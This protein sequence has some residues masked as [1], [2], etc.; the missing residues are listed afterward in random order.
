MAI[1]TIIQ[2]ILAKLAADEIAAWLPILSQKILNFAVSR[3]PEEKRKRYVEEWDAHL[4]DIPG[5]F[6]KLVYSA[7]LLRAALK[8]DWIYR[9]G[10]APST[11]YKIRRYIM[12]RQ[13]DVASSI[14]MTI[15][16]IVWL[17]LA[18]LAGCKTGDRF[19]FERHA[20][21]PRLYQIVK[22]GPERSGC[23]LWLSCLVTVSVS[24]NTLSWKWL[25]SMNRKLLES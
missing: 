14:N 5:G 6:S 7:D 21:Y 15:V 9:A 16:W 2:G 12:S 4:M 19:T 20:R 25:Q 17:S 22:L 23:P 13:R 10:L 24:L 3:L 8:M 18:E 11:M 1:L